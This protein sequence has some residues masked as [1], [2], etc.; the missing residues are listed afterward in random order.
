[1][2]LQ[3][4]L[5]SGV[6]RWFHEGYAQL[7]SGSW[8]SRDAWA[9]RFAILAGRVPSLDGLNLGFDRERVS[10]DQ[11]YMLAYTAVEYLHRMGGPTGFARLLERW[12]ESGSLD[13]AL[14]RTYGITLWQFE[15]LWRRRV[16]DQY[17]WLLVAS[18]TAVY[19][20]LL[21]IILL[22]LGYWK[23]RRDR[24]KLEALEARVQA[25]QRLE[26]GLEAGK[27]E[28]SESEIDEKQGT[29]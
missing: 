17:G 26:E 18:Q 29:A 10:A 27:R 8:H 23:R 15:R 6:P 2:A 7:A 13:L 3:R 21:T 20:S 25:Q 9:L 12:R 22:V 1:V 11:A 5:G 16:R 28:A 19:W 24:A 14:R 4:Y